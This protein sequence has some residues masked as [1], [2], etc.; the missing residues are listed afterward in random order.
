[1]ASD[2]ACF[3]VAGKPYLHHHRGWAVLPAARNRAGSGGRRGGGKGSS[4]SEKYLRHVVW[5]A[6]ILVDTWVYGYRFL[7]IYSPAYI[8]VFPA[9]DLFRAADP[10]SSARTRTRIAYLPV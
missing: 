2:K 5:G 6:D 3:A 7:G 4:S 9:R 10:S 8:T 1:M